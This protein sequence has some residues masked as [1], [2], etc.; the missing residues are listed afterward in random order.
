MYVHFPSHY[1]IVFIMDASV[2]SHRI[3]LSLSRLSQVTGLHSEATMATPLCHGH[4]RHHRLLM[5]RS[6]MRVILMSRFIRA[7]THAALWC[8]RMC[9]FSSYFSFPSSLTISLLYHFLLIMSACFLHLLV[10][11]VFMY[12]EVWY[13]CYSS[14]RTC[15]LKYYTAAVLW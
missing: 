14:S 15:I 7:T 11:L 5:E 2:N 13:C 10:A 9:F 12:V 6:T 3:F 1:L 8:Y 4:H